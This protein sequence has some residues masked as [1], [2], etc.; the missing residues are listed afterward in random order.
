[1]ALVSLNQHRFGPNERSPPW[2]TLQ[3]VMEGM[4]QGIYSLGTHYT[5]AGG[6]T[7]RGNTVSA[8]SRFS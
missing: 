2:N 6:P 7:H 1:M 4:C 5:L 8:V 3:H